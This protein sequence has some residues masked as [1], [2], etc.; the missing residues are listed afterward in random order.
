[1]I[2]FKPQV[3]KIKAARDHVAEIATRWPVD[4]Y[5]VRVVVSEPVTNAIR[6]AV[7][8]EVRVDAYAVDDVYVV[9]VWDG[10]RTLPVVCPSNPDAPSGRG[11]MIVGDLVARWGTVHDEEQGGKVVFAEWKAPCRSKGSRPIPSTRRDPH[12][13]SR[14]RTI[15]RP[16]IFD[17]WDF[18]PGQLMTPGDVAEMF[19][20][21]PKTVARWDHEGKLASIRTP[22]NVRR[23]SRQQVEHL[24]YGV[25]R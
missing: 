6:Y 1:M 14:K 22:G 17:G 4:E 23:F 5:T 13:D 11:L 8:D 21:D 3:E 15:N 25:T 10:D 24:M 2:A 18:G 16:L 12:V 19:R 20:V 7:T 9:E